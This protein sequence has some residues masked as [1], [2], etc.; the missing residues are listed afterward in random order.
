[1]SELNS[2]IQHHL[3]HFVDPYLGVDYVSSKKLKAIN[4]EDNTICL[5]IEPGYPHQREA[6]NLK[7]SIF[8]HLSPAFPHYHFH[9]QLLTKIY[10][11]SGHASIKK[12]TNIKNII[13]VGSG[14]GGVGKSTVAL[15]MALAL[16]VEGAKVGL[17]DAD[18]Y[19]PSQPTMLGIVHE[20]ARAQEKKLN[21]ISRFGIQTMSIGYLVDPSAAMVWRGPMLGKAMEQML[22]ETTWQALDYLIVDLPPGTGDV[23]LSLC[24]KIPINGAV[25]VTTPQDIA[26]ADVRRACE[27]FKKLQVPLL[28]VVE[29]M[30]GYTCSHCGRHEAIFGAGGAVKLSKEYHLNLLGQLPLH[31]NL[32]RTMDEGK[33]IVLAPEDGIAE[34]FFD[35]S[36]KV[37]GKLAL[38]G[39]DYS[40]VFP[41]VVVKN[42]VKQ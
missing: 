14:K 33:P 10:P 30:S 40:Q 9:I 23:Q 15:N 39:R 8:K 38:Q 24:Q 13:V 22:I 27:M 32:R 42:E 20:K 25:I 7:N 2:Q 5:D 19:G 29:N 31:V 11:H 21:P 3:Q 37:A 36:K 12:L 16:S 6:V 41:K 26:L 28:G 1:M 18:V 35:M 34:I 4:I 17:L